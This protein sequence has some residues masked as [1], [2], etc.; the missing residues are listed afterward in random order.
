MV[1]PQVDGHPAQDVQHLQGQ[2]GGGGRR[3]GELAEQAGIST[4]AIRHY[5]QLGILPPRPAPRSGYRS[6]DDGQ[7][8]CA[9][10][11]DLL[12]RH[13]A[14][15]DA[16]IRQLQHLRDELRQLAER[17]S[18]LDSEDCPPERVCHIIT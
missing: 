10:V 11:S 12:R 9:H 4:K 6:R 16:R 7:G 2:R 8:P 17:P 13:A 1:D 3:I 14:D 18:A 15:L 5:E